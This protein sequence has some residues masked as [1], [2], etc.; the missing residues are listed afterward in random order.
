M[1]ELPV[2]LSWAGRDVRLLTENVSYSGLFVRT[3]T[4]PPL[5]CLALLKTRL[6]PDDVLFEAHVVPVRIVRPLSGTSAPGTGLR[7]FAL[8]DEKRK[9]W[10][11]FLRHVAAAPQPVA[12]PQPPKEVPTPLPPAEGPEIDIDLEFGEEGETIDL[13]DLSAPEPSPVVPRPLPVSEAGVE[14]I[15]RRHVRHR[16][17]LKV[18]LETLDALHHLYTHDVS[19]GGTFIATT[20]DL[21]PG[22]ELRL[23]LVH[24]KSGITFSLNG[25]VRNRSERAG[26]VGLGVEFVD[27]DDA[28]REEFAQFIHAEIA[29]EEFAATYVALD[30]PRLA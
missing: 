12:A 4:P 1:H 10:E 2:A 23:H 18:N 6:A 27:L 21:A 22:V 28:R 24:P 17:E 7:F 16:T 8:G 25:L 15:R 5:Q 11:R 14:P 13:G 26:R 19:V 9:I 20:I 30:D 29:P 3:D